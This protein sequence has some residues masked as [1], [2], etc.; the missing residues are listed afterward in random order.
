MVGAQLRK[1]NAAFLTFLLSSTCLSHDCEDFCVTQ[2]FLCNTTSSVSGA[3]QCG[4]TGEQR[5]CPYT[6]KTTSLALWGSL[7]LFFFPKG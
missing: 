5:S 4:F 3:S 1:I 7:P 6:S 2:L